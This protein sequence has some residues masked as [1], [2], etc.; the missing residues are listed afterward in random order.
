MKQKPLIL[1]WIDVA[2]LIAFMTLATTGIIMRWVLPPGSGGRAGGH[3]AGKELLDLS[4][5]DWG[6]VHFWVAIFMVTLV[7]LHLCLHWG[8]IRTWIMRIGRSF[9]TKIS[10]TR[11][12]YPRASVH[13]RS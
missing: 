8:W 11:D 4:R 7:L 3:A 9:R 6:D 1:F 13:Q 2:L 10:A 5:H 12:Q